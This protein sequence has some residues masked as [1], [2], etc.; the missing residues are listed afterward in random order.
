MSGAVLV[1][2]NL[3]KMS[4]LKDASRAAVRRVAVAVL[5][6]GALLSGS[7][8]P[9]AT[10]VAAR[11]ACHCPVPM[12]C[13]QSDMCTMDGDPVR[14]GGPVLS[15]CERSS[16]DVLPVPALMQ[17]IVPARFALT[18]PSNGSN[19][20]LFATVRPLGASLSTD[21]PPPR[22]FLLS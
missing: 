20:A 1:K 3:S 15:S 12:H 6:L 10:G 19:A 11:V 21:S 5:L 14:G 2:E 4:Q 9:L 16:R 18:T 17:A 22:T 8:G 7:A 13:C